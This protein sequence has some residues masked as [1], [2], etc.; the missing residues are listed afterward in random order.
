M[1]ELI[2]Q[3]LATA[4]FSISGVLAVAEKR[5]DLLAVVVL[6]TVTAVGGGTIRDTVLDVPV[7][8]VEDFHYVWVAAGAAL[9]A[10]TLR[11]LVTRTFRALLYVDALGAALF[12]IAAMDKVL[13]AGLS[14]PVAAVFGVATA[15]GGGLIRDV[16][17]GRPTLLM[18]RELYATPVLV[19]CALYG[20]LASAAPTTPWFTFV[21]MAA[22]FAMRVL[23]IRFDVKMPEALIMHNQPHTSRA[24]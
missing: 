2:V 13:S 10:F 1:F 7:F 8:W 9:S 4:T 23:V 24:P 21:A 12:S 16:L 11:R 15:I 17:A 20:G 18:T 14:A 22:I 5:V 19:G 6:G 3:M